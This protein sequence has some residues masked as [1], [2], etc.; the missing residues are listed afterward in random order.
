MSE[1]HYDLMDLSV[2]APAIRT[3]RS[4]S[5]AAISAILAGHTT[6]T[7]RRGIPELLAAI[8][9]KFDR[10]NGVAFTE[11]EIFVGAGAK[12]VLFCLLSAILKPGDEVVVPSPHYV[13]YPG[14]VR[15]AGG[16]PVFVDVRAEPD[17]VLGVAALAKV[18]GPRTRAVILNT[19]SN[20]TGAVI[21]A[22]RLR[23]LG[24]CV[25]AHSDAYIISDELYETFVYE[26]E[27][28]SIASMSEFAAAT[29]VVNGVS[30]T[31]GMTGWRIGYA[32]GPADVIQHA[33]TIQAELSNCPS[34]IGQ[35]AGWGAITDP[36]AS[37]ETVAVQRARRDRAVA[38]LQGLPGVDVSPPSGGIYLFAD[39]THVGRDPGDPR[40]PLP[41][42]E[43]VD[44]AEAVHG[45]RLGAG[46]K[47][48][49][50]HH[51][52][53]TFAI[54]DDVLDEGLTR[55]S[56]AVAEVYRKP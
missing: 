7:P 33:V 17:Q 27:H 41:P 16:V 56:E 28:T 50:P 4:A 34:S 45:V 46:A 42:G 19:P 3:P 12:H 38:A 40:A 35:W 47:F 43:F 24:T 53:L 26:G 13:G 1:L 39:L 20:P 36:E 32:G 15:R 44:F 10:V 11:D 55:I 25:R 23:E 51:A 9:F 48:G 22:A 31:Y 49:A 30:K 5:D 52:R 18:L 6:Y 8:R 37:T 2:G 14:L 21:P 29:I 54:D